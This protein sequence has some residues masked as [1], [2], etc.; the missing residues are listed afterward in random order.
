MS[1]SAIDGSIFLVRNDPLFCFI[2]FMSV[3]STC[4]CQHATW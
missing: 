4:D 3:L 1:F 2:I